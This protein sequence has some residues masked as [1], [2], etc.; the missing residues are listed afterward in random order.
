ML[1]AVH[2]KSNVKAYLRNSDQWELLA[3]IL[4]FVPT[5]VQSALDTEN[6]SWRDL[7]GSAASHLTG[8]KGIY[9]GIAQPKTKLLD[10]V[11][12]VGT[13]IG[14]GGLIGRIKNHLSSKF[15]QGD[16]PG[17]NPKH[18]YKYV[19]GLL[20]EP[21]SL[22]FTA[23]AYFRFMPDQTKE[24]RTVLSD[25]VEATMVI[26]LGTLQTGEGSSSNEYENAIY[27]KLRPEH[28]KCT[29]T[30]IPSNRICP[31]QPFFVKRLALKPTE[32]VP[33]K[34][35]EKELPEEDAYEP[36][37]MEFDTVYFKKHPHRPG[38]MA[39]F[40]FSELLEIPLPLKV[41]QCLQIQ[42]GDK[43][44]VRFDVWER[45]IPHPHRWLQEEVRKTAGLFH[46]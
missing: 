13:G 20:D 4:S 33:T 25:I 35:E 28:F 40:K 24:L 15:R 42:E 3:L 39:Y 1:D 38:P 45:G 17:S 7:I 41:L 31:A 36:E 26:L 6:W 10:I 22:S 14:R 34:A 43:I 44:S 19:E 32:R 46:C 12:Y 18:L 16:L 23:L 5:V 37:N 8:R 30:I 29:E 21:P 27:A 11:G 2:M 9:F